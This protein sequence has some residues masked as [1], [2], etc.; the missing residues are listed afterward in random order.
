[1]IYKLSLWP[2]P[3]KKYARISERYSWGRPYPL[4][5][6]SYREHC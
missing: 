4:A 3:Y 1:M 6:F 5:G 2:D